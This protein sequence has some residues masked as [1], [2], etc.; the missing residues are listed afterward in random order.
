M[1]AIEREY[2]EFQIVT[3]FEY[4]DDE[5]GTT[6]YP[7]YTTVYEDVETGLLVTNRLRFE[8]WW[9]NQANLDTN[10]DTR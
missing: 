9:P 6:S 3:D 5:Y 8:K 7:I 4:V 10:S 2:K 1:S